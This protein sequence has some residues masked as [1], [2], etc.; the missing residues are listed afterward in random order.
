MLQRYKELQDIIAILGIDE[1]SDED[2]VT[3]NRARRLERF[4]SQPFF[5]AEQ[6]TGTPGKYVPV[7]ESIRGFKEILEGKHDDVPERAFFM[8]GSID[9]VVAEVRGDSGDSEDAGR[10]ASEDSGS[11]DNGGTEAG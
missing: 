4:L 8:K 9:E 2:K 5:V 10:G 3:V 7:E 1:L 11:E 6:F